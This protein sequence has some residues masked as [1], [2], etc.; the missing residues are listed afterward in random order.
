M[1]RPIALKGGLTGHHLLIHPSYQGGDLLIDL[2]GRGIRRVDLLQVE[3]QHEAMMSRHAA[4][5]RLAQL[6]GRSLDP[7]VCEGR[8][9]GRI[10]LTGVIIASII[11]RPLLPTMSV[12]TESSLMLATSRIF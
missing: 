9:L 11:A 10:G 8:Q 5:K 7:R 6:L 2:L 1:S 3:T 12:M 4:A